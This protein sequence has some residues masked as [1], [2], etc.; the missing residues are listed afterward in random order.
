MGVTLTSWCRWRQG[1]SA[2]EVGGDTG[3][4]G[5]LAVR[6]L[7]QVSDAAPGHRIKGKD[8]D[9]TSG[10]WRACSSP[11]RSGSKN[12]IPGTSGLSFP[13]EPVGIL[14]KASIS[15]FAFGMCLGPR[16]APL[17]ESVFPDT[18]VFTHSAVSGPS[19]W[20]RGSLFSLDSE[21]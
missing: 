16:S 13:S 19:H 18:L 17:R 21:G 12:L 7:V 4:V 8:P 10:P 6:G 11:G 1:E 3:G 5:V 2:P 15:D 14:I 20:G 9:E